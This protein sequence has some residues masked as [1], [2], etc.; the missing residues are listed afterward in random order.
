MYEVKASVFCTFLEKC[1]L[2]IVLGPREG[3]GGGWD[4]A[5]GVGGCSCK[6]VR[7]TKSGQWGKMEVKGKAHDH[8][9]RR[10]SRSSDM[11]WSW[12]LTIPF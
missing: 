1:S 6:A 2:K 7:V 12:A 9:T 11:L 8:K 4:G 10:A 5:Q 3:G